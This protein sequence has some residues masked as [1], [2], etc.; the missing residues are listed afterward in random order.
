MPLPWGARQKLSPRG[1][2]VLSASTTTSPGA[3]VQSASD[4][5]LVSRRDDRPAV[6]LVLVHVPAGAGAG[7]GSVTITLIPVVQL[8][9]VS[10]SQVMVPHCLAA[11]LAPGRLGMFAQSLM[12]SSLW[13]TGCL[14][15]H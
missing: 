5:Q 7:V 11:G 14:S 8:C 4:A 10:R 13:S 3:Q 6:H 1:S 12:L 2:V 15:D 9:V